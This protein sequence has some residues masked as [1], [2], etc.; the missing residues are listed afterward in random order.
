MAGTLSKIEVSVGP[1]ESPALLRND[2]APGDPLK[3][4]IVDL[5]VESP[6]VAAVAVEGKI[7]DIRYRNLASQ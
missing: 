5:Q 6:Y 3:W 4:S 1:G 7:A 2:I